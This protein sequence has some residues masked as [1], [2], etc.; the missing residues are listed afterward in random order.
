MF[1]VSHRL[2]GIY[3]VANATK[4]EHFPLLCISISGTK[5]VL[6]VFRSIIL[7]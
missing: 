5:F 6:Q 3:K 7:R 4:S 2:I 1:E